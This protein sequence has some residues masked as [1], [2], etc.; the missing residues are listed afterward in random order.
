[1][2]VT[3]GGLYM[4]VASEIVPWEF[5]RGIIKTLIVTTNSIRVEKAKTI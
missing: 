3:R 4:A 2:D 1:M 5:R